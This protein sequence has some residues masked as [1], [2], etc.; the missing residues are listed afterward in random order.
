MEFGV[1][2]VKDAGLI[3]AAYLLGSASVAY[4]LVRFRTG[5]DIRAVGTGTAGGSNVG[6]VLGT[7]GFVVTFL[8]DLAKGA[9]AA[10]AALYLGLAT[11]AVVSV[12]I[13]VVAGQIWPFQLGFRGGKGLATATGAT[14]VF[15]YWIVIAVVAIAGV[16]LAVSRRRTLSGLL[17]VVAAPRVAVLL[18]HPQT[19][20]VGLSVIA[21]IVLFAHRENVRDTMRPARS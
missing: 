15:D 3:V 18:D 5:Q 10:T 2:S 1:P 4:Y 8:G 6:R 7:P 9:L 14:V 11:W 21:L 17:A 13:A 19:D 12:M 20:V 16:A